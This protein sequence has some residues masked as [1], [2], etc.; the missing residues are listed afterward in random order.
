MERRGAFAA[1][2]PHRPAL[3]GVRGIALVAVLVH[4]AEPRWLPG[5]P[6]GVTMFFTLSGFLITA[7][8]IGEL[9]ANGRLDLVRF[10]TRR[11]R[12]LVP[13]SIVTVALVAALVAAGLAAT[14]LLGDAVAA[15]TWSANWRFIAQGSTYS[16]LFA[17]PSPF[18][19]L[20]SLAIEEQLYVVLPV[21]ALAVLGPSGRRRGAFLAVVGVAI[22]ASTALAFTLDGV[23]G[24][25]YYGTDARV[26]EPLVGVLLAL[27]LARDGGFASLGRVASRVSSALGV[28]ALAGLGVLVVTLSVEDPRLYRGGFLLAAVLTAVV[29]VAATQT[30]IV[31]RV[32]GVRPLARL[33]KMSY[34]VYLFHWPIFLWTN[35][36]FPTL[37]RATVIAIELG[38][39]FALAALSLVLVETPI[40]RP[41]FGSTRIFAT[42]WANASV[43]VLA[44]IAVVTIVPTTAP[45]PAVDLGVTIDDPVPPPPVVAVADTQPIAASQ[46]SVPGAPAPT[47]TPTTVTPEPIAPEEEAILTGAPPEGGGDD[48]AEG[49]AADP[50][51]GAADALRVA[52][53]GDSL[54]HNLA[55]GLTAWAAEGQDVV[56][57]DLSVSFCPLSRGGDRRWEEGHSFAVNSSCFWWNDPYSERS[58]NLAAFAP[59]V[60][61]NEASFSEMLDRY[62][63]EWGEWHRPGDTQYDQWLLQEYDA[64]FTA[65]E[66]IAGSDPQFLTVNA[67]CGDF[68][69]PRGWRRVNNPDE[70]VQALNQGVYP[71][72]RR[73]AYGDLHAELCPD[74]SFEEDL[75]GIDGAR[76][77]GMHLSDEAAAELARRWLGPLVVQV[78]GPAP[79][80]LGR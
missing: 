21:V 31:S 58:Q 36:R 5:A 59:D 57:Y 39:T 10:W 48:W 69:R 75:W 30:T 41:A 40:R 18:Q 11:A 20:W 28:V 34:G 2:L 22:A 29:L 42:G 9:E 37:D 46:P 43:A 17:E 6:L 62:Q 76:P 38:A 60:I 26:A 4:H 77:D 12:R 70:R 3:D 74:G 50:P 7:L 56:V 35:A 73:S 68:S 72:L 14:G 63:Y 52:V 65:L 33:G 64:M 27:W 51:P 79:P 71:L 67:P 61:V 15:L 8:L 66:E 55:A 49:R 25:A 54:A 47:I 13:A 23:G 80:I 78:S 53:I 1:A 45:A 32:L 44:A 16:S 19:H 24:R